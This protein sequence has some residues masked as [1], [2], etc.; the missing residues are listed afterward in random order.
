MRI[1]FRHPLVRDLARL[2]VAKLAILGLI[3]ALFFSPAHR[4]PV[5]PAARI[6]GAAPLT[7]PR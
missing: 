7:S 1:M 6:L 5:D 2:S 3:Y 4:A